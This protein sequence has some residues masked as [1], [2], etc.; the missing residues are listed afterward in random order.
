M[1]KKQNGMPLAPI[2]LFTFK[3]PEH[4]RRTLESLALNPEFAESPLFIYCDGARS[5]AE[6]AQVEET[7]R[8]V[9]SWQHPNKT[10]I[11]RDRNWGL[12]NSIIAGVT[13]LCESHGRVIVVEDDLFVSP[14]FINYLNTALEHYANE[15]S[16]MQVS[17]YMFPVSILASY[18][19]VMLPFT[20]SL[21][22]ATWSRAW[23]HFDPNMTGY[24]KL[25]IDRVLRRKFDMDGAYPYFRMLKRQSEGKVDSWA[26]RWYLSVF[27]QNGLVVFPRH[28]LVRHDGYDDTATHATRQDQSVAKEVWL[29]KINILSHV[30]E[31][32][33][34]AHVVASFF[35]KERSILN[36]VKARL[37][38]V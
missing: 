23:K 6:S 34:A 29:D 19:T 11:E 26:I 3:R 32:S 20:A 1:N 37:G 9:R 8:L 4:T 25:K 27:L 12:A 10:I 31:D 16:V 35:R 15:P 21:G 28:T 18:D 38:F 13:D 30:E 14:V 22:W 36:R 17:A 7:R 2:A 33:A 5:E 24:E